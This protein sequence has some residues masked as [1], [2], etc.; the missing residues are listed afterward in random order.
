MNKEL[1]ASIAKLI[2]EANRNSLAESKETMDKRLL[3]ISTALT[4]IADALDRDAKEDKQAEHMAALL[5]A[6]KAIKLPPEVTLT[7]EIN[8]RP[9]VTV[10]A[11]APIVKV[12]VSPTPVANHISV[13]PA[14]VTV[15]ERPA[16]KTIHV[17]FEYVG[18]RIYGAKITRE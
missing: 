16:A 4:D 11:A 8:V 9:E 7:P 18:D 17:E 13:P 2:Q 3:E 6:I 14:T 15:N 5:A 10:Q 12:N 1:N